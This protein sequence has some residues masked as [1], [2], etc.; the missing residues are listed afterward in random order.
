M[1][2][3]K[4]DSQIGQQFPWAKDSLLNKA[5][6][7]SQNMG[8]HSKDSWEYAF[9][10]SLVLE[11]LARSALANISPTLLADSKDWNNLY[12]ALGFSPKAKK[13]T[14][15]S[16]SISMV[17]SRLKDVLQDFNSD[18]ETFG[19]LHLERRNEELHSGNTPFDS[20]KNSAWLPK[21]YEVCKALLESLGE[22]L[23]FL[24]GSQEA[25]LALKLIDAANDKSAK[26]IRK[27]ISAHN[28]IWEGKPPAEKD[29]QINLAKGWA[30]KQYGHRVQCPSCDQVALVFGEASAAP[31]VS[32]ENGEITEKQEYVPNRFE[33]VACGLKISGL[34]HLSACQL[35][36]TYTATCC[37][38]AADYY[39]E[40]DDP[41]AGYEP[42]FNEP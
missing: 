27:S 32:I 30:T 22:D 28:T 18:H 5:Q 31:L 41:Y 36:D 4:L 3:F 19:V 16:I 15:R 10:S 29:E 23:G 12:S 24:F 14:P 1:R 34:S 20:I 33:C 13:F 26:A 17:F 8:S 7:Y 35:G 40:E 42:D 11:F 21:F 25:T 6:R 39:A 9:W 2:W 38:D 37:Y